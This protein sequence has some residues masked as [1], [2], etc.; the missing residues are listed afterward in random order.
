VDFLENHHSLTR[1]NVL[2]VATIAGNQPVKQF[3]N[4]GLSSPAASPISDGSPGYPE[5]RYPVRTGNTNLL[6]QRTPDGAKGSV[7]LSLLDVG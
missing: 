3:G 2:N 7:S 6:I 4:I 1:V 5:T